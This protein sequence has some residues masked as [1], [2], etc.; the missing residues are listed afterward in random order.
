MAS[1]SPYQ[2]SDVWQD[3]GQIGPI[4]DQLWLVFSR[5]ESETRQEVQSMVPS[6][7]AART[8]QKFHAALGDLVTAVSEK[9]LAAIVEVHNKMTLPTATV[10]EKFE[11]FFSAGYQLNTTR[12][13]IRT[14][15][16]IEEP[17]SNYPAL[18][19]TLGC[20]S[21]SNQK[22]FFPLAYFMNALYEKPLGDVKELEVMGWGLTRW[23]ALHQSLFLEDTGS[24]G[25]APLTALHMSDANL[26]PELAQT[27]GGVITVPL[28][29]SKPS[30]GFF[31]AF[32]QG[33]DSYSGKIFY[34]SS[35]AGEDY[36][37]WEPEYKIPVVTFNGR[38]PW[39]LRQYENL[40]RNDVDYD[41]V[42]KAMELVFWL[43]FR[44]I[45]T[46]DH[47]EEVDRVS[48]KIQSLLSRSCNPGVFKFLDQIIQVLENWSDL[49]QS[50]VR[51]GVKLKSFNHYYVIP[52]EEGISPMQPDPN[53]LWYD[54]NIGTLNLYCDTPLPHRVLRLMKVFFERIFR[55]IRSVESFVIAKQ[56]GEHSAD[57]MMAHEIRPITGALTSMFIRPIEEMK[58]L[59]EESIPLI[60]RLGRER[61]LNLEEFGFTLFRNE[62]TKAGRFINLWAQNA[63]PREAKLFVDGRVES[64]GNAITEIWENVV[65]AH[66]VASMASEIALNASLLAPED[67]RKRAFRLREE[68]SLFRDLYIGCLNLEGTKWDID[69]THLSNDTTN[70]NE[71]KFPI[72]VRVLAA[73]L[74]N[75][76]KGCDPTM[77]VSIIIEE[78]TGALRIWFENREF[79]KGNFIKNL[80]G[81]VD[82]KRL[83][84]LGSLFLR[85]T[86]SR[87]HNSL[88]VKSG[89]VLKRELV[90]LSG[91]YTSAPYGNRNYR[92]SL[93]IDDCLTY[94]SE[95]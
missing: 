95:Y 47:A 26:T 19:N 62:V 75:V 22:F 16:T 69:W 50:L 12:A 1:N 54:L 8:T 23:L 6:L 2:H 44:S 51:D 52:L 21:F 55:E 29:M 41:T 36:V 92:G 4:F 86:E 84:L 88:F 61:S 60:D 35:E 67:Y 15:A 20:G 68:F 24:K 72:L 83:N 90:K 74:A 73:I 57:E 82:S 94:K 17:S 65:A 53:A 14:G 71:I 77:P 25:L 91:A 5:L 28:D 56:I 63:S 30:Q 48:L 87:S 80:S 64:I 37:R 40:C 33:L 18:Q 43:L 85:R 9:C 49:Q 38:D 7:I 66:C 79:S 27:G 58:D 42:D 93:R 89:D 11:F 34:R 78:K 46:N 76:V 70:Q 13:R 39:K 59:F 10:A 45:F 3:G 32:Q 31:A 81:N